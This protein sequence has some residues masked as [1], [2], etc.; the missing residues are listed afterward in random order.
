[1]LRR[2]VHGEAPHSARPENPWPI[3]RE[4]ECAQAYPRG[5]RMGYPRCRRNPL[6][7]RRNLARRR[8]WLI[9]LEIGMVGLFEMA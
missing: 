7:G 4:R 8:I 1:M 5:L 3:H 6:N 2:E 9:Q